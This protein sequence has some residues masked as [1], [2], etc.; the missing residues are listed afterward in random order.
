M[1]TITTHKGGRELTLK[2][3]VTIQPTVTTA[4]TN[5]FTNIT[6]Q[7]TP[8]NLLDGGAIVIKTTVDPENNLPSGGQSLMHRMQ[9]G[10]TIPLFAI[11]ATSTGTINYQTIAVLEQ[12]GE[13]INTYNGTVQ[14]TT[15]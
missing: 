14:V 3:Y 13:I 4:T 9:A 1:N 7:V 2:P 6:A 12:T 11:Q 15:T 5:Q 8:Y 10:N